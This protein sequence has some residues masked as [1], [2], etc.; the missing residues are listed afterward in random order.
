M[1][2]EFKVKKKNGFSLIEILAIVII[3]GIISGIAIIGIK[4]LLEREETAT[5]ETLNRKIENAAH[6]YAAKYYASNIVNFC[7]SSSC[8]VP[9]ISL[10]ELTEDGLLILS[11]DECTAKGSSKISF[12]YETINSIAGVKYNYENLNADDCFSCTVGSDCKRP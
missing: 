1:K 5:N 3:V 8:V 10:K 12:S 9:E 6:L 4:K 2:G 7:N 11:D